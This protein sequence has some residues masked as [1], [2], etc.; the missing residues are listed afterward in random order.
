MPACCSS[1]LTDHHQLYSNRA[2]KGYLGRIC[3]GNEEVGYEGRS[4]GVTEDGHAQQLPRLGLF[5]W[6]NTLAA[7]NRSDT[8]L[9]M[10]Q[11]DAGDGQIWVY[12]AR[13][14]NQ[15][16]AFDKAGLTNGT[17]F[18]VDLTNESVS[19]DTGFRSAYGKAANASFDL[20]EVP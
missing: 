1:S 8:T 4:F 19:T 3:F 10:G 17:S 7:Q 15:G 13:K 5:S 14:T 16:N 20:A 2:G 12:V 6:E 18:V 11:E 9:V